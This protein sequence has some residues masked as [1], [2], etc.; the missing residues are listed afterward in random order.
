MKRVLS[1]SLGSSTRD[2]T[3]EADFMGQH[4][5]LSRQGT[6]GDLKRYVQR[7]REEDGKVDAFGVGG[8]EFYLWVNK[9]RYYFREAKQVRKA[10]KISK[11]G[12]GNGIKHLLAPMAINA[13][14]EHGINL[15]GKKA[16][17]TTAV[18]RYGLAKA[19]VDAGCNVTFGDFM[20]AL[21]LPIAMRSL[22]QVH[23]LAAVLLPVMT[24]LPFKW[25]YPL[26]EQQEKEPSTKYSYF[27]E[28]AD[29]IAGDFLQ[30]WSHLPNDLS[31]KIIITN[32]T[33]EK[34]VEELQK[35]NLH[36]LVTNTP[37]L[38]GRSFGTNVIEAMCRCLIDKPD[39][40]IIQADLRDIIERVP[41]KPQVHVLN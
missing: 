20:F 30:V 12:D 3:T 21:D 6:D 11:V 17:K 9:R 13:L 26:G 34:N 41:L 15:K 28:E 19:L 18:D 27:Y 1:I 23:I 16:L 5:W 31:G 8:T 35:R 29:V 2:H 22:R 4:F 10:I 7:F 39:N 25:L 40:E 14:R 36:I 33:T 32:T 38:Q 37:R 24:Q